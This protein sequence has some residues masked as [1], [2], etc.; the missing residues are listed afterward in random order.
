MTF[1]WIDLVLFAVTVAVTSASIGYSSG[2]LRIRYTIFARPMPPPSE[3]MIAAVSGC[4]FAIA[5]YVHLYLMMEIIALAVL[6]SAVLSWI[7]VFAVGKGAM[8]ERHRLGP[9]VIPPPV[10]KESKEE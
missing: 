2:Q 8:H 7:T 5:H 1:Q 9:E 10:K 4:A 6:C 3:Y